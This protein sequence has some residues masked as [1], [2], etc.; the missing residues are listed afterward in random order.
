MYKPNH[1]NNFLQLIKARK[2]VRKYQDRPIAKKELLKCVEAARLA[3]SASNSQPCRF[4]IIDDPEVKTR[5][6]RFAFS[7]VYAVTKWAAKAPVIVVL[8]AERDLLTNRIGKQIT[9]L[10]FYLIDA[11]IA[12]EHFILQAQDLGIGTCWI[13][14]FSEKGIKK[15]LNLPAKYKPVALIAAGYPVNPKTGRRKRKTLRDIHWFNRIR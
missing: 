1:K 9:G 11:G 12:G 7:G 2:S 10:H 6:T 8:L 14:W 13:G 15:A 5:L 4:M 3:P